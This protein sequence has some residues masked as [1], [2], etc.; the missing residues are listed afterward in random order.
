MLGQSAI[1]A[2]YPKFALLLCR[3]SEQRCRLGLSAVHAR[4]LEFALPV[5]M[6]AD[7]FSP[8]RGIDL[9]VKVPRLF[10]RT[11]TQAV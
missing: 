7:V 2:P 3:T 6:E 8:C 1:V 9:P 11:G 4:E 10:N 5:D